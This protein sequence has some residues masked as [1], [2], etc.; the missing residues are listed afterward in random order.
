MSA[1]TGDASEQTLQAKGY[2]G[3]AGTPRKTRTVQ[4]ERAGADRSARRP[5]APRR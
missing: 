1:A 3:I 2:P 5:A 4:A